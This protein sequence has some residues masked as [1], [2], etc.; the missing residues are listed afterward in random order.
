MAIAQ[1]LTFNVSSK[2]LYFVVARS[3]PRAAGSALLDRFAAIELAPDC[4]IFW[5]QLE[6]CIN[7]LFA[8]IETRLEV[9]L[10]VVIPSQFGST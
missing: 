6:S 1:L 10:R 3:I 4:S 8:W 9:T 5:L 7:F 2:S